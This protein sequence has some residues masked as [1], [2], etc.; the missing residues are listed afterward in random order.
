MVVNEDAEYTWIFVQLVVG[1]PL[2]SKSA[3]VLL[4]SKHIF[5]CEVHGII[6]NAT[7]VVLVWCHVCSFI[8][9]HFSD[10]EHASSFCIFVPK[11]LGNVWYGVDADTVEIVVQD[12]FAYP[13]V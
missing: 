2:F 8:V 4:E 11:P 9:E 7:E 12:Q 10:L 13:M 1:V 5:N 3:H 6:K